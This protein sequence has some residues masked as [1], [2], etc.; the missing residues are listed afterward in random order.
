METKKAK[1][2][3][4]NIITIILHPIVSVRLIKKGEKDFYIGSGLVINGHQK[5]G[6]HIGSSSYLGRDARLLFVR[7]YAGKTYCPR[8]RIGDNVCIGNRF[9]ALS[10]AEITIEDNCLIASDVMIT[11][12]NHG[13]DPEQTLSYADT[14]L[15]AKPVHIG[16]GCWIGEKVSILPGVSLG[17]RCIVATNAV[18]SKSFPAG[19]MVAGIPARLIKK[20]N[21]KTHQWDKVE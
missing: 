11:S 19:S 6:L 5:D 14:P 13:I 9:S 15:E 1:Q 7:E 2:I 12:E 4:K 20:Y 17:D 21:F 3:L 18:V 10:A 16:K 8:I